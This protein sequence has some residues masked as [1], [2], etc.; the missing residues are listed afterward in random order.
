MAAS[1][2]T[3]IDKLK[4]SLNELKATGKNGFEGLIA[5]TLETITG[6]PFRLAN[7]GYQRGVDG[8]ST[9]EG[10]VVFEAKLYTNDLPRA[11]VLSK[12][13]DFVRHNEYAD[14]VWV[15]GATCTV[16]SQ[17]ADDLND[18]A[19][20]EGITALVLD[21]VPS[22]FPR[23]SVALAMGGDNVDDFLKTNLKTP[24][25]KKEASAALDAIRASA[26]FDLAADII[27]KSLDAP[28]V[29]TAKAEKANARWF[30]DASSSKALA[31]SELGQP[32]APNDN[33]ITVL[34]RP[35]LIKA[36]DP[37]F[38]GFPG[39]SVV[40][41]H[42]EEGCGK[43]WTVIQSW[44]AQT[45]KPLL[46]FATPDEF[47]DTATQDEIQKL[48]IAKL[49]TQ[50]GDDKVDAS[51]T[52]WGQR[53]K[54][55]K[56][57]DKPARPRFVLVID[58][59]NQRPK[60]LWGRIIDSVATYANLH[61]GCVMFTTR[62]HYLESRVR[63]AL[64][65]VFKGILVPKWSAS[66]RDDILKQN[67]VPI[68]TLSPSVAE[69]LRNPRILSIALD[70]FGKD[71]T[72]FEELSIER[73]LLEHIMAGV[74]LDFGNDPVEFF[75]HLRA[76]AK[77]LMERVKS[78]IRD[79]LHIFESHVPAVADG[80]FFSPV[81]GEP[82][83]Y[84]LSENG[85]TLALGL[86]IIENLRRAERNNRDLHDAL[87]EILEPIEALDKTAAAVAAAITV[88][89]ADDDEYSPE[90]AKALIQGFSELQNPPSETLAALVSFAKARPLTFA[91]TTRDLCLQGGHQSNF[92]WIQA[93][94]V[95]AAKS[96]DVFVLVADEVRRW[97]R[98][99]SRDP[100][101]RMHAHPSR[102]PAEKVAQERE[103][104]QAEIEGAIASFTPAEQKRFERLVE[105]AGDLDTLSQT[106][107]LVL[108]GKKL[109]QFADALS[110]WSFANA[111]NSSYQV[112]TK[113]FLALVGFNRC[114][115]SETR[116]ELLKASEDL[117]GDGAS[118]AGKWARLKIL[119]STGASDDDQLAEE[120]WKELRKD[121]SHHFVFENSDDIAEPCDP[122]AHA[123]AKLDEVVQ[124]YQDLDVALLR[125]QMGQTAQDHTLVDDRPVVARFALDAAIEKHRE[126]ADDVLGRTGFPLRQGLLELRKHNV[127]L[128][129]EQAR[130]LIAKWKEAQTH[131]ETQGLS[132]DDAILVQYELLVA[133]PFLEAAEQLEI[134]LDTR[135]DQPLLLDVLD[136]IKSLDTDT[137]DS[138]L[139]EARASGS[140]HKQHLLLEIVAA[141]GTEISN[142]MCSFACSLISSK[143]DRLRASAIGL[144]AR[145][146]NSDLLNAVAKS[147]WTSGP[148]EEK[149]N[150]EAWYGSLALLKAAEAGLIDSTEIL[151]RISPRLY[152]RAAIILKGQVAQE[153]VR[154]V[155]ASIRCA[156]GLPEA[157][158][159][160]EI[161]LEAE[162]SRR[163]E[164]VR[165]SISE[166]EHPSATPQDF[167]KRVSESN[168]EFRERQN[169]NYDA[170]IAFREELTAAKAHIVLDRLTPEEFAAII[171]ADPTV[172]QRWFNLFMDLNDAKLPAV[173]NLIL[174]LAGAIGNS[175]P[176]KG[177]ALLERIAHSRPL[178]R[179]T[180]GKNGVDLGSKSAWSC[181]SSPAL[182][183]MRRKRLDS[184]AT[185]Q[186]IAVEALS[187]LQ[188]G[189]GNFLEKYVDEQLARAEPAEIARAI[190]IVGY[191]DQS[192]RNDQILAKFEDSAGLPGRAYAVAGA[193]YRRN[194]WA[195][196]WFEAMCKT[197]DPADFWQAGVLFTQCADGRFGV[198]RDEFEQSGK[199][200]S[201]FSAGV[202]SDLKHRYEKRSKEREKKL[203]GQD[204]PAPIFVQQD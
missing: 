24:K 199:M 29:A 101:R 181:D 7:S 198:W 47:S 111:I 74:K 82:R 147:D 156:A 71:V 146:E 46:A 109:A 87:K 6:I 110:D 38:K 43:S 58:G 154:L 64:T 152:G 103:K 151:D 114:D 17:L 186:A 9:F 42:G 177:A 18:D 112:P 21:W 19:E 130:K 120:L 91:E 54:G 100:E 150:F 95:E 119:R 99:Y 65:S 135:E 137:I 202:G 122:G 59:I 68:N 169:R 49:Q 157:L 96:D 142:E 191:S 107:F 134:L 176:E 26:R 185:D 161:E 108:A 183:A 50:T 192:H 166:K 1:L 40:C 23:L 172:A 178:V 102:D 128:K 127:I 104:R 13:P 83:K 27:R 60:R 67:N 203:F 76:H 70:V 165:F 94:L 8:K 78:Q 193:A 28:G 121:W 48:L 14:L 22:D 98:M 189:Q 144:A 97:L 153:I 201:L 30:K 16:P 123:P 180:Y 55:W 175:D 12:I 159:A 105:S 167:F 15:L 171:E 118:K 4:T 61:G 11:D 132:K 145:S 106:A 34:D 170:F 25:A 117:A 200:I 57:A 182:D 37:Y 139:T 163:E 5:V 195:R 44:L 190:M 160:P 155:D 162:E 51:A 77:T 143:N 187:A 93:S 129:P 113:D 66:E 196:H 10:A 174:L 84:E 204:A 72:A 56:N 73:L 86:S 80:R 88:C 63:K 148:S 115:W 41:I 124:R 2:Q 126:L 92:D 136:E 89:A 85:L 79:D 36:L 141:T 149:D 53:F 62:T 158:I 133:F 197:D 52:R 90:I 39:E 168:E 116:A 35:N 31:R 20:K 184:A 179:F 32:L 69:F 45:D 138:Q 164:P 81:K 125:Q 131:G 140:A 75:E 194:V 3:Q 188:C 33:A 173:H